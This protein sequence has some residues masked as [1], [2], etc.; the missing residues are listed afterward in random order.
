MEQSIAFWNLAS[1]LFAALIIL[2]AFRTLGR[3]LLNRS[4]L[5]VTVYEWEHALLY[6]AG[7]FARVLPPGRY[8]RLGI[9]TRDIYTL[10]K[11]EQL[12][13]VYPL[14]VASADKWMF[15]VGATIAYEIVDPKRAFEAND[16]DEQLQLGF[17][18][19]LTKLAGESTLEVFLTDR[20]G[21]DEKLQSSISASPVGCV[22]KAVTI[23]SVVLPPEIRRMITEVERA[24]TEGLAALERARG[25]HAA[26]R[27]L[28]NASR[29]LKGN[30]ELM[31]LRILQTL[32][33]NPGKRAPTL[34]LG[35]GA[36]LPVSPGSNASEE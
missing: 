26:I 16:R 12:L 29:L 24:K 2:L 34:V 35:Q 20:A 11:H 27:S 19:A 15:R 8:F 31:N 17:V 36:L 33:A 21:L 25:E 28:A 22:V 18:R 7:Q 13:A 30:A 14:D 10:R 5:L 32:N 3:W 9:A 4:E 23:T 6:V 1:A